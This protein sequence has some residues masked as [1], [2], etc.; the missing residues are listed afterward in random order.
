MNYHFKIT[1]NMRVIFFIFPLEWNFAFECKNKKILA[2][3]K[4]LFN[5][6]I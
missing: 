2:N 5:G 6:D 3:S 1:F 4:Y